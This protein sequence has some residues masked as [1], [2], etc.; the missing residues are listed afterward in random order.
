MVQRAFGL[1]D[2]VCPE[3]SGAIDRE[4]QVCDDHQPGTDEVCPNCGRQDEILVLYQC[5][6]CKFSGAAAPGDVVTQHPAVIAFYY[7]HGINL[8]YNLD[9]Q[10]VN[11]VLEISER[12]EQ[13]VE[14]LDPF[15][16]R[17]TIQLEGDGLELLLDGDM[18][19]L[20]VTD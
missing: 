9:F 18:N 4:L 1:I 12:H 17:V 5:I 20:E 6:V 8:L 11:Q 2:G 19:V 3:C 10:E 16:V 13:T 15:R 14:S 7:E